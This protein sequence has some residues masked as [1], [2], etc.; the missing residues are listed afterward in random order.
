MN[1]IKVTLVAL[2]LSA[3]GF[4][5]NAIAAGNVASATM[6]VS[7]VVLESCTVQTA[8]ASKAPSVACAHQAPVRVSTQAAQSVQ[9]AQA[10]QAAASSQTMAATDGQAWQIYF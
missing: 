9:A 10:I 8:D 2:L 1:K 4:T 3:F 7:F 6:Q 5:G